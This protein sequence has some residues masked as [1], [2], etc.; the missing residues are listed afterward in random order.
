LATANS[1]GMQIRHAFADAG[2]RGWLH[3]R[4][5]RRRGLA[6]EVAVDP[7]QVVPLASVY[8]LPLLVAFARA[9]D[10]GLIDPR[11]RTTLRP[12]RRVGGSP[13]I[14]SMHD[15]VTIS[16]RDLVASMI[17]VSDNAAAEAL[18]DKIG[19]AE[20]ETT[21]SS[22]GLINTVVRG[23]ESDELRF[24]V[25]ATGTKNAQAALRKLASND[26]RVQ[27]GYTALGRSFSTPRELTTILSAIWTGRAASAT[28]CRFARDLLTASTGPNRLKSGFPFD[29]VIV[30][31]KSGTFGALRHDVGVVEYPGEPAVAVAVLTEAARSDQR[32]PEVDAVIGHVARL[33]VDNL[34]TAIT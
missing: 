11:A 25:K 15:P 26:Q 32:L 31:N 7:D 30:A 29:S 3:A 18:Y 33:A 5:V 22:L 16:W 17:T 34:R 1:I 4:P 28:Q 2:V 19:A 12:L 8:K 9:V 27:V 13:G 20:V 21:I 24:L 10:R 6:A 14:A 23:T